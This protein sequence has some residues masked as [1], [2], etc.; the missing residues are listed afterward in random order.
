[1]NPILRN[2][3][4]VIAGII[5]GSIINGG[6]VFVSNLIVPLP[7]GVNPMDIE[8]I[9]A[10]IPNYEA[11]HWI[12]PFLAHALGTLV[13]AFTAAKLAVSNYRTLAFVIGGVFLLGGIKMAIDLPSPMGFEI[14]D[15]VCAY[16]P[17]AWLGWKL[18]GKP[19]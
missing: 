15:I 9:K 8:S 13:G 1:M 7:E 17:M 3:L 6:L 16:F 18:S 12:M 19:Q 5:A 2:I 10:A 4:A 14:F 11:K